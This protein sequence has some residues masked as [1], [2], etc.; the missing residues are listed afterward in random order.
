[1]LIKALCSFSLSI[2]LCFGAMAQTNEFRSKG[3]VRFTG[4]RKTNLT[5]IT[6][7][8]VLDTL[9]EFNIELVK[10]NTQ[11]IKNIPGIGQ[12]TY[13][14]DTI[15]SKIVTT[16][17]IEEIRTFLPIINF[18]GI[19]GNLW[20]QLG[21]TDN[22]WLGKGHQIATSYQNNNGLHSGQLYYKVPRLLQSKLGYS[23]SLTSWRSLEPLYFSD[24]TVDYKYNINSIGFTGI[25]NYSVNRKIELGI[26]AFQENYKKAAYDDNE[27]IPGPK[28]LTQNKLLSK[29]EYDKNYINYHYFYLS[30]HEWKLTYQNVY[31]TDD[32]SWF[33]SVQAESK[34]FF[35][36]T[37][38]SNVAIRLKLGIASNNDSPFAP[39]VVDSH[40]NLRGVGNRI[41]R[42]TAQAVL[43]IEYRRTVWHKNK[44]GAQL[45]GFTDVGTWRNPGGG[46]DDLYNSDNF[47]QFVGGGF[48]IIYQKVFGAILRVDYGIDVY[49]RQD[50]GFVIGLGQY[51]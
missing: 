37:N 43:N 7:Q 27:N 13:R 29:I 26:T 41:D 39:F 8:L 17:N 10:A 18:G 15:N 36:P 48:R 6:N 32:R 50:K 25:Y 16:Y 24:A 21:L 45:V 11:I 1:M 23:V 30:G 4:L 3:D 12:A 40:T 19:K 49:N 2:V 38:L 5:F 9:N 34:L 51:F 46:F 14:I 44:W 20:Y 42:G 35:R 33:N 47:R 31:T 22:N 28:T